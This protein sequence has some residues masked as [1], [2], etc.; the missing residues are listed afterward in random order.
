M[1]LSSKTAELARSSVALLDHALGLPPAQ[2]GQEVDEAE[3]E[4]AQLRDVLIA[5]LR[6]GQSAVREPLDRVNAALS[7]LVGVEY[8]AAGIQ[9]D[10]LKQ[11]RDTL[12]A[13][14]AT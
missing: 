8:P 11:A 6:A 13:I 9:R 1:V 3:R 7:L 10:A 4:I 14:A 5:E 2:L 12:A